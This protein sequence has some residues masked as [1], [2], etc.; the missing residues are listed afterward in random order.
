[1]TA[2]DQNT[3]ALDSDK[4]P[5]ASDPA[6]QITGQSAEILKTA[7]PNMFRMFRGAPTYRDEGI[8]DISNEVVV[9]ED[10]KLHNKSE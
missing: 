3:K 6:C 7:I 10:G 5:D 1:M 4:L 9:T 8:L 2:P